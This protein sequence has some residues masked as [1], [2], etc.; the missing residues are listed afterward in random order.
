MRYIEFKLL[1]ASALLVLAAQTQAA[2]SP[3]LG[4]ATFNEF[5]KDRSNQANDSDDMLEVKILD[6]SIDSS[7]YETWTVRVCEVN[8]AGNNNDN[9]GCSPT[10]SV[11]DFGD[12]VAPW[13]ILKDG[14]IGRYMNFKTQFDAILKDG[15]GDVIDYVSVDGGSD[16]EEAG[17]PSSSM[18]YPFSAGQ[19][20][21]TDKFIFRI[22][23]GTGSWDFESS[24]SAVPT[25]NASND[26]NSGFNLT[27]DDAIVTAGSTA[28]VNVNLSP[29]STGTVTVDYYTFDGDA[30]DG[31]DY[32]G[33]S[34]TL[35]FS[36]GETLE[37]INIPTDSN[38]EGSFYVVLTDS[39][40][41]V[42]FDSIAEVTIN[43]GPAVDH[44]EISVA[45]TTVIVCEAASITIEAHDDNHDPVE[46]GDGTAILL[47]TFNVTDFV[48]PG[49]GF[50]SSPSAGSV[51]NSGNGSATYTFS[52]NSS[53]TLAFNYAT[54]GK[55]INFNINSGSTPVEQEEQQISFVE[56]GFRIVDSDGLA[57]DVPDQISGL[58][59]GVLYLE[60]IRT[61]T[62]TQECEGLFPGGS[63]A[64]IGF[65]V[66]CIDPSSCT[67]GT[68]LIL[69]YDGGD[70]DTALDDSQ[71]LTAQDDSGSPTYTTISNVAF[72]SD[73]IAQLQVEYPDAGR[74]NLAA[75]YTYDIDQD[76]TDETIDG[77]SNIDFIPAGICVEALDMGMLASECDDGD[78]LCSVYVTA[79]DD[80][81]VRVS[82]KAYAAGG[83]INSDFCD[84][85]TTDNFRMGSFNLTHAMVA[86]SYALADYSDN[87]FEIT[88]SGQAE[89]NQTFADVGVISLSSPS[90]S[91]FGSTIA[92]STSANIGRFIPA[93]FVVSEL[94]GVDN[95]QPAD[96]S[97]SYFG[98]EFSLSYGVSA[99]NRNGV[100]TGNYVGSF[101]KLNLS[102]RGPVDDV[103]APTND[104][105]YAA[106]DSG[107]E[108]AI[109]F[110]TLST[111]G[112]SVGFASVD[113]LD[114]SL[115]RPVSATSPLTATE[116]A[117]Y[118]ED[119]DGVAIQTVD[120]DVSVNQ[121]GDDM[122]RLSGS[123]GSVYYGRAV[124]PPV[125]GPE[126]N[127][128]DTTDLAIE[129]Q[130]W[131]G[132]SWV[133]NSA[134]NG[135][136]YSGWSSSCSDPDTGD[137]LSCD[138]ADINI[139]GS[140][141]VVTGGLSNT[142][143]KP[144]TLPITIDRPGEGGD[145]TLLWTFDV[146]PWLEFD[147]DGDGS[148]DDDPTATVSF[149][150]FRGHD[151]IIYWR[152]VTK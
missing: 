112:W 78:A 141:T 54:P 146:D 150:S 83:E 134:D 15:N 26:G 85:T 89:V 137:G 30:E 122:L 132:S 17:C 90:L 82:G 152:E 120:I 66:E 147:W 119:S 114:L 41:A 61:D 129:I 40:G 75:R 135:S 143:T 44:Y 65:A 92:A 51:S 3:Y 21:N 104:V 81:T 93:Y 87:A 2:C 148:N 13:L 28:T 113:N 39:S 74:V 117:I 6:G 151:R 48:T 130:Y 106:V 101:A 1:F 46:P 32:T 69:S 115:S 88:A 99:L 138:P 10:I 124:F 56:A 37:T 23:D 49:G 43:A 110:G 52:T 149:G 68:D 9:D 11:G 33:V 35:T 50:W 64:D 12:T 79:G 72:N 144:G 131:D 91:Y 96:S 42:V 19:P 34:G 59:S 103:Y 100:I 136:D 70:A 18:P 107:T 121:A 5:F 29:S 73:S 108:Y 95:V 128:G 111:T 36:P 133:I 62:E 67:G 126:I 38:G 20:G 145:G 14:N 142:S 86:G 47:S 25:E 116:V 118:L 8:E 57:S 102:N 84:N 123:P 98:Q 60:A 80:F 31:T 105:A 7:I 4:F 77:N 22:P 76:S 24:A 45:S 53:V 127:A 55:T 58:Q 109:D 71:T 97:Y 125:Y 139:P 140:S 94:G 63:T 16:L 27:I